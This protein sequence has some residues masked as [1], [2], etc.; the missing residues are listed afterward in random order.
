MLNSGTEAEKQAAC[1]NW[2]AGFLVRTVGRLE[3][4]RMDMSRKVP[5]LVGPACDL[6]FV[7]SA[8]SWFFYSLD[9]LN[10]SK[11]F[12][13]YY[14]TWC[15]WSWEIMLSYRGTGLFSAKGGETET[16]KSKRICW[17]ALRLGGQSWA[18]ISGLK[19]SPK[20][21]LWR[22]SPTHAGELYQSTDFQASFDFIYLRSKIKQLPPLKKPKLKKKI[23][24]YASICCYGKK[25]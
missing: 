19:P 5:Q 7:L 14:L 25:K 11:A 4:V 3:Q 15:P 23:Y 22:V 13:L 6:L 9:G 10:F 8:D 20:F 17:F 24:Y 18:W 12:R 1:W 21:L 2:W 16:Q